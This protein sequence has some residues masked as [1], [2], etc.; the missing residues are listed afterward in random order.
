MK[1]LF[2]RKKLCVSPVSSR[3]EIKRKRRHSSSLPLEGEGGPPQVVDEVDLSF[4]RKSK[5]PFE[6]K[7]F[8]IPPVSSRIERKR[9]RRHSS[10]RPLSRRKE[11]DLTIVHCSDFIR[12]FDRR[13]PQKKPPRS[14]GRWHG[15]SARRDGGDC[16]GFGYYFSLFAFNQPHP[17]SS[18]VPLPLPGE[19]LTMRTPHSFSLR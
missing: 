12:P 3:I 5:G 16:H 15:V 14:K 19:G 11:D 8:Y 4:L 9:K 18:T 10:S 1:G 13:R 17:P 7:K 6:R 2:E